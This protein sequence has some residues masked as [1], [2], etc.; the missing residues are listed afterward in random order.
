MEAE[1]G[2]HK[3]LWTRHKNE[4]A[5]I[6]SPKVAS[7]LFNRIIEQVIQY[8]ATILTRNI[9]HRLNQGTLPRYPII[10]HTEGHI[11]A[12]PDDIS[13]KDKTKWVRIE[14]EDTSDLTSAFGNLGM[15]T[16]KSKKGLFPETT[17]D[18]VQVYERVYHIPL[19]TLDHEVPDQ[20]IHDFEMG[21][22]K[23]GNAITINGHYVRLRDSV[24]T[25]KGTMIGLPRRTTKGEEIWLIK[26]LKGG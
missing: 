20:V 9:E 19:W 3:G 17:N 23:Y 18:P 12:S 25:T 26:A 8:R 4:I 7:D 11:V 10:P 6:T 15:I 1:F 5:K 16:P 14:V 13:P 2:Y 24:S 22:L 21:L